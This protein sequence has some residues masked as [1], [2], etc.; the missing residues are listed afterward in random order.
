MLSRNRLIRWILLTLGLVAVI[1]L[2]GL[3]IYSMYELRNSVTESNNSRQIRKA[4][5][6]TL[7]V[8]SEVFAPFFR[9]SRLDLEPLENLEQNN[10]AFPESI[11]E[12]I[13]EFSDTPLYTSVYYTPAG[14]DPCINGTEV[15]TYN[16][17]EQEMNKTS[18]YSSL[19]CD[20]V[21]LVRTK[22]RI[23]LND[24]EYQWNTNVE[25]DT[26]RSMN[27]GLINLPE[28]RVIG[29][30]TFILN[31]DYIINKL[32]APLIQEYFGS[33]N[34]NG[35][36]VWLHDFIKDEVLV[37]N[38][39]GTPFSYEAT[40]AL[41]RFPR[42]FDNWN[43]KLG[44]LDSRIATTYTATF[45]K[46]IIVLGIAVL[47]LLGALLF[48]FFTAQRERS[49]SQRQAGFLANVTHELKTP[50]AVMQAA[51]EN[52]SDGRVT[53]PDRLMKYGKHIYDESVRLRKMI[54]KMLDVAKYDSGSQKLFDSVPCQINFVVA[55]YLHQAKEMLDKNG[56]EVNL[57]VTGEIPYSKIDPDNIETIVSNLVENAIK[58]SKKN[59]KID[60]RIYLYKNR[61]FLEIEDYGIGIKKKDLKNIFRKFYRVENSLVARTKGHGLGLSIVKSLVVLNYGII[62]VKSEYGQ[63]TT[64][65]ISFPT[66]SKHEFTRQSKKSS[67]ISS[68]NLK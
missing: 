52:I 19:L 2:T 25:F 36:A 12:M 49:L 10:G 57:E 14:S 53:E 29:Y 64:F 60:L 40:D 28:Y 43:I 1:A 67:I 18:I 48:M 35:T 59:K 6:I 8:R 42:F 20:G 11:M 65:K 15:Y 39:T 26:H 4:E 58:Y 9:L 55:E 63:G 27:I 3:N 50:L 7:K 41:V 16:N 46:N 56:F 51:G 24:L 31:K 37:T 66:I 62:T 68:E 22:T 30:F 44:F 13:R 23:Q 32:I 54:D 5:E 34:E 17:K 47:F 38:N 45:F 61:V 33:N 21:G